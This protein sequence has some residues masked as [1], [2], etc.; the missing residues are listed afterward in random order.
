MK[1]HDYIIIGAG[2]SG[3]CI[4]HKL[5][6]HTNSVLLID[7]LSDVGEGASKAAGAFL[8]P[9]LGKPN[10]FKD[11]V[12]EALVFSISFY[13]K[14]T[15]NLIT[16][17]GTLRIPK[18]KKAKEQFK[19][20]MPYISCDYKEKEDG[21][22]FKN[23]SVVDATNICKVLTKNVDKL[24]NYE[25]LNYKLI[26]DY[27][28]IN[29][30]IKAKNIIV[31]TGACI[32]LIDEEYINIRSVWGQ[33]IVLETSTCIDINYHKECSISKTIQ[34]DK[35]TFITSIGA[36]HH[37]FVINKKID[38]SDTKELLKKANEILNLKDIN[39]INELAGARAC[40][41]DYIPLL[42]KIIDS[43]K[44]INKFPYLKNG[45]N[46]Q[47]DRLIEYKKLFILNGV[48]GRGF[49][50]APFLANKLVENIVN[51]TKIDNRLKVNRLFKRWV[52]KI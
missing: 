44:T 24:L 18:D 49:V 23:A 20:Y 36:T 12:N 5:L 3:C 48:G 19:S 52:R 43:K 17:C 4:A 25:V 33:R 34:K 14:N 41:V 11:L 22:Y 13:K 16:Q 7:K 45:T 15:P 9:L 21:Y 37:R 30:D 6:E 51:N 31:A 1:I 8:S 39:I 42:G 28:Y 38:K 47:D 27:W 46:V 35:N 10:Y 40:S 2:I 50:L 29:D 26:D 32:N